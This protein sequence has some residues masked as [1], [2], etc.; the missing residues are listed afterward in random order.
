MPSKRKS[1]LVL[2]AVALVSGLALAGCSTSASSGSSGSSS[3]NSSSSGMA[4]MDHGSMPMTPVS[5]APS[6]GGFNDADVMFA[7]MMIP[8]H[9]QAVEMSDI[10]LAKTGVDSRVT[11]LAQKI[12]AA[13]QPEIDELTSWLSAWGKPAPSSSSHSMEGMGDGM[14][15]SDDMAKLKAVDGSAASK[16]FLSQMID[17]HE[18]AVEMAKTEASSGSDAKAVAMAKSI[19]ETQTAEIAE[20]KALLAS[21]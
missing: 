15:S 6:S 12:K 14:M 20:M 2:S 10:V 8:H 3:S 11:A 21:L 4:G 16:L 17:H 1:A 5:A 18:G 9:R 19:V 13:Q 7:Q